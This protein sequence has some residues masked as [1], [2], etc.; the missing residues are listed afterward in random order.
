M[1][2]GKKYV[3]SFINISSSLS[4]NTDSGYLVGITT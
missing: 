4:G 3:D 2:H 1:K